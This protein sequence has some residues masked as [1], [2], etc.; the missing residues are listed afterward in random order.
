MAGVGIIGAI[1]IGGLA[2][3]LAG[4]IMRGGGFGLL[5]NIGVGI[6]GSFAGG[7]LFNLVDISIG[8]GWVGSLI[9]S[10][11][12]AVVLLWIIGLIKK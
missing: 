8:A 2:G 6:V 5:G 9:T 3:W 10:T 7:F 12:G 4:K 11:I 1:V